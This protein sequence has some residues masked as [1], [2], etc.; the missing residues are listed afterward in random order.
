MARWLTSLIPALRRQI[1]EFEASLVYKVSCR[2]ATPIQKNPVSKIKNKQT[3]L[4]S[5]YYSR[6]PSVVCLVE[7][8]S[9]LICIYMHIY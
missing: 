9:L 7:L 5:R 1:C 8:I 4:L 6:Y 2:T 3:R